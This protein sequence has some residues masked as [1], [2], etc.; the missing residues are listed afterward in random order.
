MARALLALLCTFGIFA[1]VFGLWSL[2]VYLTTPHK[3]AYTLVPLPPSKLKPATT[4]TSTTTSPEV[5][6]TATS[7]KT[8]DTEKTSTSSPINPE[9]TPEPTPSI[10][11]VVPTATYLTITTGCT[12]SLNGDC[13]HAFS[14]PSAKSTIRTALRIGAVL[15]V[16]G[17]TTTADGTTWYQID[18]DEALRYPE[19]LTLPWYVR[20]DAGELTTT[21]G[22]RD[23]QATTPSTTKSLLVDRGDQKMYT[24]DGDTLVRTYIIS[25][26]KDLSPTPRGTFTIYRMTP[27]RYMQGPIPGI[28]TTYYD[29]PGVPWNLY[30]TKEGAVVHGAYWHD[31]FGHQHSNGCVNLRPTDAKDLYDWADLGMKITVRD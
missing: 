21:T 27:S 16:K 20:S 1:V 4:A 9:P 10:P 5:E 6:A 24:Y 19:R 2:N 31:D 13:K 30:F 18:F 14:R 25:T 28:N 22:P 17:S 11:I 26:G 29:L 23:L 8:I 3:P 15:L 12:I 7:A